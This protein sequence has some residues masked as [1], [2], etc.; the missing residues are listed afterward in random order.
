MTGAFVAEV[1]MITGS[2]LISVIVMES[3]ITILFS[4]VTATASVIVISNIVFT[5]SLQLEWVLFDSCAAV[6]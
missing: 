3:D 1:I 5:N 2:L 6:V 4:K